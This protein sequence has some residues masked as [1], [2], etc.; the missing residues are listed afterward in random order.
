MRRGLT[1][2]P[3]VKKRISF[4]EQLAGGFTLVELLLAVGIFA[5]CLCGILLTY[6]G[7]L[8]LS[9]LSRDLTLG[10]NA[11]QAKMEEMKNTGFD[12]LS[13]FNGTTFAINGFSISYAKGRIEVCDN[14]TCPALVPYGDLKRVRIVACF[15]SRGRVIGEDKNLNGSLDIGMGE[16]T[17]G[18]TRLDSPV[19]LLTL[20]AK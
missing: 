11:V 5:V 1:P 2:A 15:K 7:M 6:I 8:L 20:I 19:E 14:V 17:N 4:N 9:D 10:T 18:N 3:I 12:S 13:S 16:D